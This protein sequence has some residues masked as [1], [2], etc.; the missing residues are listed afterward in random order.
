LVLCHYWLLCSSNF[1]DLVL[2]MTDQDPIVIAAALCRSFEGLYLKPYLCPAAVPTI[3]YGT[4]R[5][6]NGVR[7]TLADEPIT[8]ERAEELL[9]HELRTECMP[10]VMRLCSNLGAWGPSAVAAIVDFVYNLGSGNLASST[11]RKKI[12]ADDREGAKEQIVRWVYGGGKVLPGLVKRR[13]A[14]KELL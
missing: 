1:C 6:E 5:Y 3:G 12:L 8:K 13:D 14:E 7:V 11:L 10:R 4:T 2:R 9:M